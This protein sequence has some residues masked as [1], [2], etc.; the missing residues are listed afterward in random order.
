MILF[1][2]EF[3]IEIFH[4]MSFIICCNKLLPKKKVQ[5]SAISV[6]RNVCRVFS[7]FSSFPEAFIGYFRMYIFK[8]YGQINIF[9][10]C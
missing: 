7:L 2:A 8:Y 3:L 10:L 4:E 6:L 1:I 5:S 9:F